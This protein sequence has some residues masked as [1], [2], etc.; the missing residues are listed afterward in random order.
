VR[1]RL[2]FLTAPVIILVAGLATRADRPAEAAFPG[3]NGDILFTS[4]RVPNGDSELYLMR[5][6]GTHQR[7]LTHTRGFEDAPAWSRSGRRIA[8]VKDPQRGCPQIY[9][10]RADGTHRRRLAHDRWC[11]GD[12]AWS[13]D[14]QRLAFCRY[15]GTAGK[16]SIWTMNVNG[17]GLRRLT[18]G[19]LDR[20]PAWSPDGAT[21]AFVRPRGIWLVDADGTHQRQLTKPPRHPDASDE[22]DFA[23]NWSPDGAWIAFSRQ[24]EPHLGNSYMPRDRFDIYV[25][26]PDGSGRRRLT[27]LSGVNV[28][29]AWSP[30]GRRIAFASDRAHEDRM[31]IYVM[32]AN[33]T[34]Q[35]RLTRGTVD[36]SWPD[37][38]PL[39]LTQAR[40]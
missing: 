8:Y 12:P 22:E 38:R 1:R 25:I 31:D 17:T 28:F 20:D 10:M 26:R 16:V 21:I 32:N 30:N 39:P 18:D 27:R 3:R 14:G 33:G 29:P 19:N 9:L 11:Y 23:P 36:N 34:R 24:H 7:R 40:P 4:L 2:L 5:P 37:W 15:R 6:D 35:R 13:P